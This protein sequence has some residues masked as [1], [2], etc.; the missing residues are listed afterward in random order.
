[1]WVC[2]GVCLVQSGM[3]VCHPRRRVSCW[4]V[5]LCVLLKS[6]CESMCCSVFVFLSESDITCVV[7]VGLCGCTCVYTYL[8]KRRCGLVLK[9]AAFRAGWSQLCAPVLSC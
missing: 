7:A 8:P 1:M 3:F 6:V 2:P 4:V 5:C 9:P